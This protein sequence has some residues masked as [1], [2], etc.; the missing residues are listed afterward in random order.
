MSDL[1]QHFDSPRE[2]TAAAQRVRERALDLELAP[3][4]VIEVLERWGESLRGPTVDAIPGVAFLRLWLRRGTLEPIVVRELGVGGLNG[5]W[6]EEGSARLRPYPL[7]VIGHW[8]AG[9]IEIQP[10]LSL[11]CALLGG[12]AC[13][14]RVPAGLLG[15]TRALLEKL[16]E[17]EGG[18]PLLERI[19]IASFEHERADLQ[20]AMAAAV[21]GAMIWGGAEAVTQIRALPFPPWARLAVFGPRLSVAAMDGASWSG[22]PHRQ[23]W[24]R[25]LA[26]DVWQFDQQACSSPQA[27]FLERCAAG[28]LAEFAAML[29]A[30]FEAEN[31]LHPRESIHPALTSAICLARASWLL[32]DSAHRALF[33]VTPDWT[34]LLGAGA[35]VPSPTQGRTLSVLLVED[36]LEPIAR[37]D[38]MVQ[39]LGLAVADHAKEAALT[40]AAGRNGVDRIVKLGRMHVFGSPWDG[41]ELIR[42]MVRLVRHVPAN[43]D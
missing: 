14:V 15:Q 32:D 28:D 12:N 35:T 9:N 7:G 23:S 17:V 18:S 43:A 37:F 13:L 4:Q 20:R 42:P 29:A 3:A 11:S 24:C 40:Q 10:L 33:P 21:D 38:G 22:G 6:H 2:V 16:S 30:A 19:C 1:L 41:T 39:T 26:R 8:P 25:R 5:E 36:L 27:L 31:R 34:L